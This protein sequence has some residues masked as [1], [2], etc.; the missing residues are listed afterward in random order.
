MVDYDDDDVVCCCDDETR[1]LKNRHTCISYYF[2]FER[3]SGSQIKRLK[4]SLL[5]IP[6][7]RCHDVVKLR[8][9]ADVIEQ[10]Q[11]HK[12]CRKSIFSSY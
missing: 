12:R 10:H 7:N 1:Q 9:A 11:N 8:H 6:I 4:Q 2:L 5:S 3:E